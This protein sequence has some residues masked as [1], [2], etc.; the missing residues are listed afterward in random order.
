MKVCDMA[1]YDNIWHYL[2]RT[3]TL[4]LEFSIINDNIR[5]YMAAYD[6]IFASFSIYITQITFPS[7]LH[8]LYGHI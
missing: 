4:M 8:A 6:T 1:L 2:E 5:Q 7:M 3:G